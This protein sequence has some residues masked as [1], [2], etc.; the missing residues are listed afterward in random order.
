[1]TKNTD[2]IRLTDDA[3]AQR[4]FLRQ[5]SV[6]DVLRRWPATLDAAALVESLRPLQPRLYDIANGDDGQD[7]LHLTVQS[8]WYH[9]HNQLTPGIASNYLTGIQPGETVRLYPH[10][11]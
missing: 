8:Y 1:K 11:N 2:L 5:H 6:L 4:E 3:K 9:H 7:E 10:H